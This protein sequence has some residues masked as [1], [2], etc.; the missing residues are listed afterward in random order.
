MHVSGFLKYR[1]RE[2][3]DLD[4]SEW[5]GRDLTANLYLNWMPSET[6]SWFAGYNYL[7][8]ESDTHLCIPVM[9][10]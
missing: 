5:S 9:D 3:T 7:T 10:G 8:D 1:E 4:H 2:N 6:W